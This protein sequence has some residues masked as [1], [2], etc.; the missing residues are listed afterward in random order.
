MPRA[1]KGRTRRLLLWCAATDR[2]FERAEQAG[3]SVL[4]G[5]CIHCGARHVLEQDGTPR[6]R[7]T[8]EHIVPRHHGGRDDLGNLAIACARCNFSKGHRLDAR[9][10]DDPTLQRVIATLQA[11]RRERM[12]PPL[13][14]LELP[15]PPDDAASDDE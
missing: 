7:A 3:R 4:C 10:W 9:R 12:R 13:P 6:T 8:V 14:G 5:K 11:R 2:S 15:P 1:S